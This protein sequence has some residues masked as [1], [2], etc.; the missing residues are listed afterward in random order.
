[1]VIRTQL[2][3]YHRAHL[4]TGFAGDWCVSWLTLTYNNRTLTYTN[5]STDHHDNVLD[6][7]KIKNVTVIK[8]GKNLS[9]PDSALPVLVVDATDRS[10]YLQVM[11]FS[12]SLYFTTRNK[13][14]ALTL[15]KRFD[16][17]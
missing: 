14:I 7:K 3:I 8:N 17:F 13:S 4:K 10:I 5:T 11:S 2:S 6:L 1:M 16:V 9:A 15:I 12:Q